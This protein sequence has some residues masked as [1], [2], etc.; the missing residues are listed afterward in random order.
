MANVFNSVFENSIRI[1]LLL[2][3]FREPKN[4][5]IIYCVDFM[6]SYGEFFGLSS[7]N[8]NGENPYMFSEFAVRRAFVK[9]ALKELA[10]F[11]L[12]KPTNTNEGISY[13]ITESGMAFSRSLESKYALEYRNVAK[14]AVQSVAGQS[15]S[16]VISRINKMSAM[17][18][19]RETAR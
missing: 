11:G 12:V 13:Q 9:N 7:N 18:L 10:L 15:G 19:R 5:D 4:L 2:D 1:I 6:V 17:N 16:A 14:K 8:L 3:E